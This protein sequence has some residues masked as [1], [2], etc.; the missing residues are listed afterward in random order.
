MYISLCMVLAELTSICLC[1]HHWT[2]SLSFFF[3]FI[4]RT[5]GLHLGGSR[6]NVILR[7]A[8]GH[9]PVSSAFLALEFLFYVLWLEQEESLPC[10][11]VLTLCSSV[12]FCHVCVQCLASPS[13]QL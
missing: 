1:S 7:L 9:L 10:Y 5:C 8:R 4:L 3:F 11:A 12:M 6:N 13:S 2:L